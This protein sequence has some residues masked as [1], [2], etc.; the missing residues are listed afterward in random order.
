MAPAFSLALVVS[1]LLHTQCTR[2]NSSRLPARPS[3]AA[4]APGPRSAHLSLLPDPHLPSSPQVL[5]PFDP[6]LLG[7]TVR[8]RVTFTS[9]FH[10]R[11]DVLHM[12]H[13]PPPG[14]AASM[15]RAAAAAAVAASLPAAAVPQAAAADIVATSAGEEIVLA[16]TLA[17]QAGRAASEPAAAAPA[18]TCSGGEREEDRCYTHGHAAGEGVDQPV[19]LGSAEPAGYGCSP[20]DHRAGVEGSAAGGQDSR[21]QQGRLGKEACE[22]AVR[23]IQPAS[24]PP[25]SVMARVAL[26]A[27]CMAMAGAV[28]LRVIRRWAATPR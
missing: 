22:E 7:A 27:A 25:S 11:A 1:W 6:A 8:V 24:L 4:P 12:L 17:M 13:R 10:V 28:S 3:S 21:R 20:R 26:G 19:A 2:P 18:Y 14:P 9:K 5:L 15:A 23:T 16:V